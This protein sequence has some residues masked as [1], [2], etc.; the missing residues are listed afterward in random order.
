MYIVPNFHLFLMIES[1]YQVS[2]VGADAPIKLVLL[3]PVKTKYPSVNTW[4][5][6][7]GLIIIDHH[8]CTK[9]ELSMFRKSFIL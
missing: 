3:A 8:K 2:Q 5:T 1:Q 7:D 4:C 6:S 9:L